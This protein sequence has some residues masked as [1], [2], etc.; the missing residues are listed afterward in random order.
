MPINDKFAIVGLACLFPGASTPSEFWHNLQAGIDSRGEGSA[1]IFG[2]ADADYAGTQ[3]QIYCTRGGFIDYFAFDGS[4]YHLPAEYLLGLDRMFH[5]AIQV[6]NEAMRDAGLS[7]RESATPPGRIGLILGNAA[8]PS[9]TSTKSGKGLWFSAIDRALGHAGFRV[10]PLIANLNT[11]PALADPLSSTHNIWAGGMPAKVAGAALGISG[12]HFAVD[13]ACASAL[14]SLKL[15]CDY[16]AA[17]RADAMLAGALSGQDTQSTHLAFSDLHAY[18]RSGFSQPFDARSDGTLTGQGA[19]MTVVKRLADAMR[20]GDRI[21][22]VIESIAL[23]NDGTGRHALVPQLSGQID[24]YRRAYSQAGIDPSSV[25]YLECHA[26]GTS[27]GDTIELAGV[28]EF[29]GLSSPPYFGSVKAN[30]GH[31][32]TAAGMPSLIKAI[33]AMHRGSIP[34]TPGV[35]DPIDGAGQLVQTV[36]PWPAEKPQRRAGV[37]SF[38]FGGTNAHLVLTAS[39]VDP[40]VSSSPRR[41]LPRMTI[42]GMGCHLGP[43]ASLDEF[44]GAI[45]HGRDGFRPLPPH[46]WRDLHSGSSAQPIVHEGAYIDEFD[47]DTARFRIPPADLDGFNEQRS[48][49]CKV[50]DEA[51]RDAGFERP[52]IGRR[53]PQRIAVIVAAEMN[54]AAHTYAARF[55]AD[56]HMSRSFESSGLTANSEAVGELISAVQQSIGPALAPNAVLSFLGGT[57]T[58]VSSLWNFTGPAFTVSGDS[59]GGA[60]ALEAAA[61]ILLD[62]SVNAVLVGAVDFAGNLENMLARLGLAAG[63]GKPG[64]GI[65]GAGGWRVGEGAAALVLKR[66]DDVSGGY[67]T[68]DAISIRHDVASVDMSTN[69]EIIGQTIRATLASASIDPGDV[70]YV[71]MHSSGIP[72]QDG[73][74]L[75][76]LCKVWPANASGDRRTALGAASALVGDTQLVSTMANVIQVALNLYHCR[77]P[78]VPAWR[79]PSASFE[80]MLSDSS[81]YVP[82]DSRPWLRR[83]KGEPRRAVINSLGTAGTYVGL[84]LSGASVRGETVMVETSAV[85]R[86]VMVP[87]GGSDLDDL[88]SRIVEL[89]NGFARGDALCS[90]ARSGAPKPHDRLTAVICSAASDGFE[91][92][93]HQAVARIPTAHRNNQEW[94]T[95]AGSFYTPSPIG[96][97]GKVALVYPGMLTAYP[98]L[99]ADM[100][101]IFPGLLPMVE[102]EVECLA[103]LMQVDLLYPRDIHPIGPEHQAAATE[104]LLQDFMSMVDIG[105]TFAWLSTKA[106]RELLH[107]RVD[108]AVGYSLGES[109]MLYAF[110]A[111]APSSYGQADRDRMSQVFHNQLSGPKH[112]VRQAWRIDNQVPDDQVWA[113]SVVFDCAE[114]VSAAVAQYDRVFLT[115]VNTPT[116]VVIAGDPGQ[117]AELVAALGS[118]SLPAGVSQVLHCPIP[119][120][121]QLARSLYRETKPVDDVR[122]FSGSN[123]APISDFEAEA[124]ARNVATTLRQT[125]D[126]PRLVSSMYGQGYRYF[127]EVGPG[128]TCSRWIRETLTDSPHLAESVDRRREVAATGFGRVVA[129]LIGHQVPVDATPFLPAQSRVNLD[130]PSVHRIKRGGP[131]VTDVVDATARPVIEQLLSPISQAQGTPPITFPD[132]PEFDVLATSHPTPEAYDPNSQTSIHSGGLMSHSHEV[133][134]HRQLTEFATG[135]IANAFGPEYAPIDQYRRRVRLPADPYHF[136]SRVTAID[137]E[138]GK[139]ERSSIQTEYDVPLGAWYTVDGQVPAGITAEAGQCDLVLSSYIGVDFDNKGERVYRLL[140]G[141]LT[142]C[143]PAIREGQRLRYDITIER[144]L[145]TAGPTLFF[146]SYKCYADGN[147]AFTMK[148]GCAGF[149]TDAELAGARGILEGPQPRTPVGMTPYFKPLARTARTS[150]TKTEIDKLAKAE[151]AEV[152]GPSYTQEPG[153][154]LSL[155]LNS[156]KLQMVD[157]IVHIDLDGGVNKRGSCVAVKRLQPDEWYFASHFIDDPVMPGTLAAEG[158]MQVLQTY[159]LYAGLHLCLPDATYQPI[160]GLETT[161]KVRGQITPETSQIRFNLSIVDIGLLPRPYVVADVVVNAD[162]TPVATLTNLGLEIREKPGSAYRPERNGKVPHFLGR[163]GA[164]GSPAMLSELHIAHIAQGDHAMLGEEFEVCREMPRVSRLPSAEMSFIDRMMDISAERGDLSLGAAIET[165]YDVPDDAWYLAENGYPVIPNFALMEAGL[166][167]S[168]L[169]PYYLG[170]TLRFPAYDFYFR[171][172]SGKATVLRRVDLRGKTIRTR[173]VMTSNDSL[174]GVILHRGTFEHSVDGEV[175]YTGEGLSGFFSS[176]GRSGG[177]GLDNGREAP[178]WTDTVNLTAANITELDLHH[179]RSKTG[180]LQLANERLDLLDGVQVV[181]RGGRYGHGYL[182][183]Y[184]NA[185][186]QDWYFPLHFYQDAVMPGSLGVETVLSGMRAYIMATG[187]ADH[188]PDAHFDHPSGVTLEWNYGGEFSPRDSRFDFEVHIKEVRDEHGAVSV[189]GDASVWRNKHRIYEFTNIAVAVVPEADTR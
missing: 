165:E 131:A 109:S 108:G 113:A 157:E 117:C 50:A 106:L 34:P 134:T 111:C 120:P 32:L 16:L 112:A 179:L 126:F 178:F 66:A 2:S 49:F 175:F 161:S 41:E 138:L 174:G 169:A 154:N 38:G 70:G 33:L 71:A 90:L 128:G 158:C 116:E 72:A 180:S 39:P 166:Q 23:T 182:R 37:S 77:I 30:V 153:A 132:R 144:F 104:L 173:S 171:N 184:R 162:D 97:E 8:F 149:F 186:A 81:F 150:L 54:P 121:Q 52:T 44:E 21:Y 69:S 151:F 89:Q 76:G 176:A 74:E 105:S 114:K 124:I 167:A 145:R 61:L 31:L 62:E 85:H 60:T 148:N 103:E 168:V 143:G 99:G 26:T 42:I 156:S 35:N 82:T 68:I 152:F 107:L 118:S 140:D 13:G 96:A 142:A 19:G 135:T 73:A 91:D 127:I 1:E 98:G 102:S 94:T 58:K 4:G 79:G 55:E 146:F 188:L 115:H 159:A 53:D 100:Y 137:A 183:G 147:L 17:G 3:Q 78:V 63:S 80:G 163:R 11:S 56:R 160:Q 125:V 36:T 28:K 110:G 15:A 129:K 86:Q 172:L 20:D 29:F 177:N 185:S 9:S 87:I 59:A 40:T 64:L 45:H 95:P 139:F 101:R 65:G 155:R 10:D 170:S 136:V 122:L 25:Q 84:A 27:L 88:M 164:D 67:A 6:G 22:A 189:I 7:E 119:N 18:P 141:S 93:L 83:A 130:G 14:Y 12:P 92:Q 5:W 187:L 24:A 181:S 47:C 48:L 57:A 123:F 75:E 46:M 133:L 43:F 51:L